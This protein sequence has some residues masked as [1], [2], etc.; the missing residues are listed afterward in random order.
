MATLFFLAG[1]LAVTAGVWGLAGF[2][3]AL[4]FIGVALVILGVLTEASPAS[5]RKAPSR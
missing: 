3:W 4:V 1:I 2:W 5:D